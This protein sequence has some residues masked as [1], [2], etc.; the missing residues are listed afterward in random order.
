MPNAD[1]KAYYDAAFARFD[2]AGE[3]LFGAA[4]R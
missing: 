3:A 2:A 4:A 1:A